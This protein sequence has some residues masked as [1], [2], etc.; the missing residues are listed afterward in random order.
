MAFA[1]RPLVIEF[2]VAGLRCRHD[3]DRRA[4]NRAA[5]NLGSDF[6]VAKGPGDSLHRERLG[7][8][9]APQPIQFVVVARNTEFPLGLAV[10]GFQLFVAE[11]PGAPDTVKP[12]QVE[13]AWNESRT[14]AAPC[15]C[16]SADHPVIAGLE[17]V[18]AA[19]GVI[20]ISLG[21][22]LLLGQFQLSVFRGGREFPAPQFL[23]RRIHVA[24]V[25]WGIH[26]VMKLDALIEGGAV[27][28]GLKD[29][30][31]VVAQL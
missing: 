15:P 30:Y 17:G 10:P 21:P 29:Q 18:L 13:I 27:I 24:A 2:R 22:R 14:V 20:K 19:V 1:G 28:A 26:R 3:V 6:G 25:T 4:A 23:V 8:K 5:L 7:A 12:W 9:A 31:L 16:A 11:R